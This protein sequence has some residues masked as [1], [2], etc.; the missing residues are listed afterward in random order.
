LIQPFF[1][2]VFITAGDAIKENYKLDSTP[3]Q[4]LPGSQNIYLFILNGD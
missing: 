2:T 4:P 1:A 3:Y